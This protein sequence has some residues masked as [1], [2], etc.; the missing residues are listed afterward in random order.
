MQSTFRL[1][2]LLSGCLVAVLALA[3][4]ATLYRS[5]GLLAP[6]TGLEA[7][8]APMAR[9]AADFEQALTLAPAKEQSYRE[10]AQAYRVA[11]DDPSARDV[12]QRAVAAN[13]QAVWA[14]RGLAT[15][16]QV[17]GDYPTA[18]VALAE[19]AALAPDDTSLAAEL[20][21]AQAMAVHQEQVSAFWADQGPNNRAEFT[22][23]GVTAPGGWTLVG[24]VADQGRLIGGQPTPVWYAWAAPPE[25]DA[26]RPAGA[27]WQQIAAG[28]WLQAA[29]E[30]TNLLGNGSFDD[31]SS[32]GSPSLQSA[33][34]AVRFPTDL[35]A[36]D[37]ATR[38]VRSVRRQGITTNAAVLV[39]GR[40]APATSLVSPLLPVT[41]G[42]AYLQRGLVRSIDGRAF[43]GRRWH[44]ANGQMQEEYP[45]A[46]A[47][48]PAWK[49]F[50][51]VAAPPA[52]AAAVEVLL[53]N[54]DTTG[55]AYFDDLL[56]IPLTIPAPG[57]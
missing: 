19:A 49:S 40:S 35:Y 48:D 10:L 24:Y 41:A 18:A 33:S 27:G 37:P 51:Q 6:Q 36:A 23:V 42:Q 56:L 53:L 4:A 9:A 38:Q 17:Q 28:L 31:I 7:P 3:A 8:I 21:H 46:A 20:A 34:L 26:S 11:G 25:Q 29:G 16:A 45:A 12:W 22:P 43:L 54:A 30:V 13:P 2:V 32:Q 50:A 44:G 47:S 5:H 57:H 15:A 1:R 39:N 55:T 52:G 14:W